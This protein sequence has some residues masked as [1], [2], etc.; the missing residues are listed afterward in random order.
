[1]M[2]SKSD[3]KSMIQKSLISP[4]FVSQELD[5]EGGERLSGHERLFE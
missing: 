3:L 1:M 2:G 4:I 5:G